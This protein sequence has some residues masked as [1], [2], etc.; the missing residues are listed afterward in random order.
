MENS[1]D[2]CKAAFTSSRPLRV[3]LVPDATY[4]ICGTIA[5][6][7]ARHNPEI[8]AR[9]C[10]GKVLRSL[11]N[12]Q[13]YLGHFDLV[14]FLTPHDANKNLADFQGRVATVTTIHHV[15]DERNTHSVAVSDGVMTASMQWHTRLK[16]M[17]VPGEKITVVPYG[18]DT[19]VF[20]PRSAEDR[21]ACR[22]ALGLPDD[23]FVVG[24]VAKR[25]SDAHG[26][27][28]T[29]VFI[30]G[31]HRLA[32]SM[33][34]LHVLIVGPGWEGVAT[35][36]AR[37]GVVCV[38]KPFIVEEEAFAQVYAAMDVY[39]CTSTIEG[40][41]V[42]V[43]EAMASGVCCLATEAGMVPDIVNSGENGFIL[44]FDDDGAFA[45]HTQVLA[46]DGGLRDS[47]GVAAACMIRKSFDWSISA[48]RVL[49]LY[50]KSYAHFVERFK[51]IARSTA[52]VPPWPEKWIAAEE[53]ALAVRFL[54]DAQHPP[55][56][57]T[58]KLRQLAENRWVRSWSRRLTQGP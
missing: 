38:R 34:N 24:F 28:G 46:N 55:L 15:Q 56:A 2:T 30:R 49:P 10:S 17:G 52:T 3:L 14:H 44:P 22:S 39:W 7:Y 16:A 31:I 1:H 33:P 21:I 48:R 4:W 45:R 40:G 18:V 13:Q 36:L 26:R 50:E 6:A 25:S 9:I 42:P 57:F 37:H 54:R 32:E 53:E 12:I 23:T 29:D 58:K 43:L 51:S 5:R 8:D 11:P 20:R 47:V 35:K 41:P 19:T 27:K